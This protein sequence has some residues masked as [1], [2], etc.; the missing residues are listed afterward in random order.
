V[1]DTEPPRALEAVGAALG[2]FHRPFRPL[3]ARDG[4]ETTYSGPVETVLEKDVNETY[5]VMAFPV[6]ALKDYAAAYALDVLQ[7]LL[8]CGDASLL[9]QEIKEKRR[10]ATSIQAG[11]GSSRYP[12]LFH[13]YYTCDEAKRPDLEKAALEQIDRVAQEPPA[14]QA[15]ERARRL[16]VNAHAFSLETTNGESAS[17]G[18]Y[19]TITGATRFERDYMGEI[20]NVSAERVQ[21]QAQ[22]CLKPEAM[23]R[24]AVRPK[25]AG[26]RARR[27]SA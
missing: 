24:V 12:D 18:Y 7:F 27:S 16:L 6:P 13:V 1:G 4:A 9:Y 2:G 8:G 23:T 25:R 22:R 3:V 21:E 11:C 14:P 26:S 17:I 10:L 15:L 19:Y 5:G 20:A